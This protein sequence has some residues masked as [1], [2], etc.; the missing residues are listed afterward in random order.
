[1][2]SS[3]CK[4]KIYAYLYPFPVLLAPKHFSGTFLLWIHY[5]ALNKLLA[6]YV[7]TRPWSPFAL[8]TLK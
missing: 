8:T 4:Q 5:G 1:M 6:E 7:I 2:I 3:I